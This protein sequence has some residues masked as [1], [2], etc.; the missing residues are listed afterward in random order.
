[1]RKRIAIDIDGVLANFN[2]A[3]SKKALDIGVN[4]K[5]IQTEEVE[6]W[7]W[8]TQQLD[9]TEKE[10]TDTWEALK[11]SYNWW[12]T[13][14]PI[15]SVGHN[16]EDEVD[17]INDAIL[18]NDIYFITHRC[19]TLGFNATMQ[20]HLWLESVGIQAHNATV[21]ASG[22]KGPLAAALGIDVVIDDKLDNLW[23]FK[24]NNVNAVCRAWKYNTRWSPRVD[25]ITEFI[26]KYIY[27]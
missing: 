18:D 27:S 17:F 26:R 8:P 21:I 15:I 1:M 10:Y 22:T 14:E 20:S 25:S 24:L 13:L 9:W 19:N 11:N 6:V 4:T 16:F 7:D 3:F 23:D 2:L 12:M 5:I